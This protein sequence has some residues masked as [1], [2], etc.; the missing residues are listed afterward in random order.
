[1]SN[2][3]SVLTRS[4]QVAGAKRRQ[5]REQIKEIVFDD[6]ARLE[7][8]TGFHKRKLAK[9]EAGKKK[10]IER[11]KAERSELRREKRQ[12]LAKQAAENAKK[13][14][15]AYG[16]A[17][18]ENGSD[19]DFHGFGSEPGPSSPPAERQDEYSDEEQLATVTV[20]EDFDPLAL[21]HGT[22]TD[23]DLENDNDDTQSPPRT[24]TSTK[25]SAAKQNVSATKKKVRPKDIKYETKA[26]RKTARAKQHARKTEKAERAGGKGSRRKIGSGGKGSGGKGKRR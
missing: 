22:S 18:L 3:L 9:K 12:M 17:A 16:G 13:V 20:V 24:T 14:E 26:A 4:H 11:E 2:N 23:A 10:A 5:K 7:F 21:I 1:M 19:D 8:L 25:T 15:T 6:E